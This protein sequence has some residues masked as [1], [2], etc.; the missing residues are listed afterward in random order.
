MSK[1]NIDAATVLIAQF[2]HRFLCQRKN[3]TDTSTVKSVSKF[4]G[5]TQRMARAL[6]LRSSAKQ[7]AYAPAVKGRRRARC[8]AE[9][10]IDT[11]ET[12]QPLFELQL[13]PLPVHSRLAYSFGS[14]KCRSADSRLRYKAIP[15]PLRPQHFS[16]KL[17]SMPAALALRE[18]QWPASLNLAHTCSKNGN[19]LCP[20]P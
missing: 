7:I 13:A 15:K 18:A 11:T 19:G 14:V 16:P 6:P 12:W 1:A 3:P 20:S 8:S 4:S 5:T 17:R 2:P 9:E 10:N